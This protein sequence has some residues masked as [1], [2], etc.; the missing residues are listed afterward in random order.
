[1]SHFRTIITQYTDT[2]PLLQAQL[3][4]G[5]APLVH[6]KAKLDVEKYQEEYLKAK[7]QAEKNGEEFTMIDLSG[8][9]TVYSTD[10]PQP[11]MSYSDDFRYASEGDE[12]FAV[13]QLITAEIIVHRDQ[14]GGCSNDVGFAWTGD[15]Y[16]FLRS[17]Y[18]ANCGKCSDRMDFPYRLTENYTRQTAHEFARKNNMEVSEER[19][20]QGIQIK[21]R[22]RQNT[23][24]SSRQQVATRR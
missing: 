15:K 23:K 16:L 20:E 21:L 17:D 24:S 14:V 12:F 7:Q 9:I 8:C 11:C 18:D 10:T 5:F 6:G 4:L 22:P 1:M 3:Y 19:T 13:D 2:I